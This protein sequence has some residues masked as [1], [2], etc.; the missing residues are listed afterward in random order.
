MQR[1][2]QAAADPQQQLAF[3]LLR[4]L[5]TSLANECLSMS[6]VLLAQEIAAMEKMHA[7]ALGSGPGRAAAE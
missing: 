4:E 1:A 6:D 7:A 3:R 5:W 2:G